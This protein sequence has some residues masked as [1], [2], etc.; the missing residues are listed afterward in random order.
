MMAWFGMPF[1]QNTSQATSQIGQPGFPF[2]L[3][4][5]AGRNGFGIGDLVF[6]RS[7]QLSLGL[8]KQS[9]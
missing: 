3:G 9:F 4:H 2:C 6:Q 5:F 8:E 7:K 1:Y